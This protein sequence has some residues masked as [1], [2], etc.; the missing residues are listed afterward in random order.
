MIC[1]KIMVGGLVKGAKRLY[2]NNNNNIS[3]IRLWHYIH[4]CISPITFQIPKSPDDSYKTI[5]ANHPSYKAN[6][7]RC[8]EGRPLSYP[9]SIGFKLQLIGFNSI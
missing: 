5:Q 8:D 2:N 3:C 7:G 9:I 4:S 6:R 1:M